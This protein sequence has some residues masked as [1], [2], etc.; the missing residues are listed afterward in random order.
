M[1]TIDSAMERAS[2]SL[3]DNDQALSA[4]FKI[5]ATSTNSLDSINDRGVHFSLTEM[6]VTQLGEV[7]KSYSGY[8][9]LKLEVELQ[10]AKLYVYGL[11]FILQPGGDNAGLQQTES[12]RPIILH[13]AFMAACTLVEHIAALVKLSVP[14]GFYPNGHL[15]FLPK[16]YF[17]ALF[18]ASA[19][20][21]RFLASAI[22]RS[23]DQEARA[24]A[25]II[26][27]HTIFQSFPAHRDMIR[28]A[29]H[30]ETWM[31]MIRNIAHGSMAPLNGLVVTNKLGASVHHDAAFRS[32]KHRNRNPTTGESPPVQEWKSL[33]E[34]ESQ[35]LEKAPVLTPQGG[36][37]SI[38]ARITDSPVSVHALQQPP[39]QDASW[40]ANWQAHMD[41]FEVGIDQWG[42][43]DRSMSQ[44]DDAFMDMDFIF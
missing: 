16:Y 14:S 23:S 17:T 29:I 22:N 41:A 2:S 37:D 26:E 34:T 30:I 10:S 21:F 5:V 38:G 27:S 12:H 18:S 20:L 28:A 39:M 13:Q 3:I 24:I 7:K 43:G 31:N 25:S 11:T 19:F 1:K 15:T 9:N 8:W 40:W 33:N 35:R 32:A 4:I 44:S 36:D 6:F 42:T